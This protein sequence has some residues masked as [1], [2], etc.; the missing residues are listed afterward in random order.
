MLCREIL[1][2]DPFPGTKYG[3]VAKGTKWEEVAEN[4]NKIQQVF[5]KVDKGAVRDRY[6]LLS[7]EL[8][9]NLKREEI[10]SRIKADMT[11]VEMAVQ[12][13]T[14]KE[15]AAVTGQRVVENQKKVKDSQDRE[16][17][18][19]VRKKAMERLG[20][21]RVKAKE[22]RRRKDRAK[23]NKSNKLVGYWPS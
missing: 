12:E 4:L 7:K 14:E 17:A 19:S 3:T 21:T 23:E 16:N 15:D 22:K 1:V 6:N 5:F 9:N 18:E 20:Q 2:G 11:E 8:R 13:L 10:E